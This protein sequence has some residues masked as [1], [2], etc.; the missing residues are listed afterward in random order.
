[1]GRNE[2]TESGDH[3]GASGVSLVEVLIALS[4]LTI[5][6]LSVAG[7]T[8]SVG[9]QTNWATWQTDQALAGQ[10]VLERVQQ[11]GFDA[12]VSGTDTVTI[13]NRTYVV[14]RVVSQVAPRVKEVRATVVS[15]GSAAP[16]TF[17]T[18]LHKPRPLPPPPSP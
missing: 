9:A 8:L 11:A 4:I 14:N 15:S 12:A 1:M 7:I 17:V 2:P 16:R 13:G 10:Q 5:G 3:T 6:M 18:R